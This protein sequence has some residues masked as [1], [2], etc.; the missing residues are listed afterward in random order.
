MF[1][2]PGRFY[3]YLSYGIHWCVNIVCGPQDVGAAVLI[4]A[5]EPA[6]GVET[7]QERRGRKP[8][9]ELTSGPGRVGQALGAGPWLNGTVAHLEPPD[10]EREV[11]A[12][13]ADRDHQGGRSA[14][15][16]PRPGFAVCE[17]SRAPGCVESGDGGDGRDSLLDE[18]EWR[19]MVQQVAGRERLTELLA[20]GQATVY[21]GFDPTADSMHIGNLVPLL[22]LARFQRAGHRPI[23]LIGGG[24]GLIGDPSG[25]SSERTLQD[26]G[27]VADW[28]GRFRKQAGR[29]LDFDSGAALLLDNRE[30]L[31]PLSAIELL[32]D[33]GKHFPVGW[34]LGKE[35]VRARMEGEGLS[36]TEFSYM[37]LQAYDFLHL[38]REE[39]CLI[40]IGGS[41]QFGNITA[42]IELIRRAAGASA[43]GMT[44]PLVTNAARGEVRQ[45]RRRRDLARPG[46]D[47][48]VRLLPVLDQ[49]R[50]SR[51]GALPE[52]VHVPRPR[53]DLRA[54][55]G[56]GCPSRAAG[57]AARPRCGDDHDA[58]RA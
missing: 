2:P 34:M 25:R 19:G 11:V 40:Q 36:Y 12:T 47:L 30:W 4:R 20:A 22:A 50:G 24:T 44:F 55:G 46:S 27:T 33:V 32:R 45:V 5:L 31:V 9:R 39:N 15:A 48:P 51:C 42:G 23:V 49:H 10:R 57:G 16:L 37:V 7:M 43:A 35:S 8:L 3:V 29:L 18:L 56:A 14:L 21:C 6:H 54:G 52:A 13:R 41:D 26:A 58:P 1:G 53:A 38:F 28:A 17:P